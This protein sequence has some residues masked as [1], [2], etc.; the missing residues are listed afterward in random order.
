MT[1]LASVPASKE[2]RKSAHELEIE[3]LMSLSGEAL[4]N[5]DLAMLKR[6][7]DCRASLTEIEVTLE[8]VKETKKARVSELESAILEASR[9]FD[10]RQLALGFG[11]NE[12]PKG[13]S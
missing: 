4:T 1:T 6:I 10:N 8:G 9:H 3:R 2:R 12:Q 7:R 13:A 5:E 11:P